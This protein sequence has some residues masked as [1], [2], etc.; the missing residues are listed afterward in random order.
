ME[1][2]NKLQHI[3]QGLPQANTRDY[4]HIQLTP[5]EEEKALNYWRMLKSRQLDEDEKK[6]KRQQ[7]IQLAMAPWTVKQLEEHV[8]HRAQAYPFKFKIDKDNEE[9]FNLLLLYFTNSQEFEQHGM[10]NEAGEIMQQ[11]S[12][13]KGICLHSEE[14]G[15]GKTLLMNLFCQ[16]KK[17]CFVVVPTAKISNF[18]A[19]EG[20]KIINRFS[21]PWKAERDGHYFYQSPIGIC[22]DDLGDE[23]I[24]NYYG[25]R[26]NVMNKILTRIYGESEDKSVFPYF[27]V[28]T[29]LT[30]P[31][32]EERYDKRVRSR[33]REMFNWIVLP[34]KDRRR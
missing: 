32:L 30:G 15:T 16:N 31:E 22:F 9:V 28:T 8:L 11:Y 1:R 17:N 4:S 3:S 13:S 21:A 25:N 19:L 10:R 34:G 14:R 2:Q 18:F 12:L 27:H 5:E 29:N 7:M 33:M 23:E 6:L 20:D 24:K 26:E